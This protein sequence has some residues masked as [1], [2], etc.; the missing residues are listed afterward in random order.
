MHADYATREK[1]VRTWSG[2]GLDEHSSKKESKDEIGEQRWNESAN[3]SKSRS[4]VAWVHDD[5]ETSVIARPKSR[6]AAAA[7]LITSA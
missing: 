4:A 6:L 7:A 3:V 1:R 2:N 5:P